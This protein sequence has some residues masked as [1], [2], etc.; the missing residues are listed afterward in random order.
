MQRC[1]QLR[2]QT[3][4]REARGG[5]RST[6]SRLAICRT[7]GR[8]IQTTGALQCVTRG[9]CRLLVAEGGPHRKRQ[10]AGGRGQGATAGI[11][12]GLVGDSRE[13]RREGAPNRQQTVVAFVL[14]TPLGPPVGAGQE[15]RGGLSA[16]VHGPH[17]VDHVARLEVKAPARSVRQAAYGRSYVTVCNAGCQ[18][19]TLGACKD[20]A[21]LQLAAEE[22]RG[23]TAPAFSRP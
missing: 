14:T 8:P 7:S 11:L 18:A 1:L 10:G 2:S 21:A 17:R 6:A 3:S 9:R 22:A 15:G 19:W 16:F 5:P 20:G 12:D 23:F 13:L 4:R